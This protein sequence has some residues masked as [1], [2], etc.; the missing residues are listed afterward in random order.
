MS[1]NKSNFFD[2]INIRKYYIYLLKY[3]YELFNNN[4]C[5]QYFKPYIRYHP[6][7]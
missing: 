5:Y 3:K 7:I 6:I 4:V 1:I 2:F